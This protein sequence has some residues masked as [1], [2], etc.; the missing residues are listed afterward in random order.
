MSCGCR[1]P[2]IYLI[3]KEAGELEGQTGWCKRLRALLLLYRTP[4]LKHDFPTARAPVAP[5]RA[6]LPHTVDRRL[7]HSLALVDALP[8]PELAQEPIPSHACGSIS[9]PGLITLYQV[10]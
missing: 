7:R 6:A 2:W 8:A 4:V 3:G 9:G 5:E 10:L 1:L